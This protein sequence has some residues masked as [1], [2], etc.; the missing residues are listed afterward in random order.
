MAT[1]KQC[2]AC[3]ETWNPDDHRGGY[4]SETDQMACMAT[5]VAPSYTSR[6]YNWHRTSEA[7]DLCQTCA[8]E[9]LQLIEDKSK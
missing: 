8:R 7:Y 1:L 2:D 5:V 6:N 3:F 4:P 9:I